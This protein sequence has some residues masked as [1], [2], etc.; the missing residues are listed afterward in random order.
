MWMALCVVWEFEGDG[1]AGQENE[2]EG[3]LGAVEAVGAADEEA[4]LGVEPFVAAVREPALGGGVDAGA[5]FTDGTPGFDEL[6]DAAALGPSAP[7]IQQFDDG[8][9]VQVTGKSL[10]QRFL[11]LIGAPKYPAGAFHFP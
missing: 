10:T 11:E 6:G 5:V 8:G 1:P 2:R 9:R 7:A 4:D 3:G